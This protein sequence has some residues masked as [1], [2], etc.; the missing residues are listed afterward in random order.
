VFFTHREPTHTIQ[1]DANGVPEFH[2]GRDSRGGA[3]TRSRTN[4]MSGADAPTPF[5]GEYAISN[6]QFWT[7]SRD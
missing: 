3:E 7:I 1:G 6:R 5:T 2:V 4:F